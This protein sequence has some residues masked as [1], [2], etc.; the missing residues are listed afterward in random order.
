MSFV[1]RSASSANQNIQIGPDNR[2]RTSLRPFRSITGRNQ[3]S[4][5]E[6]VSTFEMAERDHP[7]EEG[8]G[9]AYI[10]F[11]SQE[12]GIAA[13]LSGDPRLAEAYAGGDL[14]MSF[15]KQSGRA[16]SNA[17]KASHQ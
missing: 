4:A 7:T 1:N 12:I 9:I 10:D 6:F 17:T 14:Y 5:S 13:G 3:P 11:V 16:P 2:A 15:A 8:Y